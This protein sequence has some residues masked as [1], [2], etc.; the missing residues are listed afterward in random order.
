MDS[1]QLSTLEYIVELWDIN[2]VFVADITAIISGGLKITMPLNDIDEISFSIDLVQFEKLCASIG[3]RPINILEPYRTDVKIRRNGTYLVGAHVVQ[4]NVNFDNSGTNKVD[5]QCTGYLNHLKDRYVSAHYSGMTYAKIARQLITDTQSAYNQIS[6][7]DFYEGLSG[8]V[9]VES[10][11]IAW[12]KLVGH[13]TLGALYANV[14]AGANGFGGARWNRN[15]VAGVTYTAT[16][17][18]KADTTGGNTYIQTQTGVRMNVTP[19]TT[20]NWTQVTYTWTQAAV[21]SYID[22]KMDT[23]VNFYLDDVTLTDNIDNASNRNFGIT[24]GVDYASGAQ[25]TTRIRNYDLQN[26]K[27]G[28]INLTK[29]DNDNFDFAFDANK[30]FTVWNRKGSDKPNIE[31]VYPQNIVSLKTVRS[32]ATMANK[33]YGL[34][35]GIGEE[36]LQSNVIDYVAA[37]TYRVREVTK[38]YNSV[39]L[40]P[41]LTANATGDLYNLKDLN[42][43][44]EVVVTNNAL[45]LGLVEVGDAIYVRVDG[46]GYVDYVN[47]LYHIMKIGVD[48]TTEFDETLT[49]TLEKWT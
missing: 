49:L 30:V 14:S 23:N 27:D 40:L 39:E 7:G 46:S 42:S 31:L 20:T 3:A 32:A 25:D 29:L 24:L 21:S 43:D 34:G 2:G 8:W 1:Q 15:M 4:T 18:V 44:I 16:Y 11:Y 19:I 33:V 13:N 10:G 38:M 47:G 36:R 6:N 37:T 17:W 12:N 22:F 48:I 28:I 5:V 9:Y 35:A 26:V 45:D 41:T